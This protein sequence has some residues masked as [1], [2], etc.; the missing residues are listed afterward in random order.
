MEQSV[1]VPTHKQGHILDWIVY[2][3]DDNI[4]LSSTVTNKLTSDHL[5][6]LCNLDLTVPEPITEQRLR[7]NINSIDKQQFSLDIKLELD[8]VGNP[9]AEQFHC[10]LRSILDNHAP[11]SSA[12]VRQHKYSPWYRE[13]CAELQA[14]KRIRRKAE[15]RWLSS[16]LTV[17]KEIY[18]EA[19]MQVTKIVHNAKSEY[20]SS[21]IA[22]CT[23][24]K[25]LFNV[26]DKL[27][28]RNIALPLPTSVS[29]ECLPKLFSTFFHDKVAKI[30]EHLDSG[31]TTHELPSP[32]SHDVEYQHT[33]FT[34]FEP[35]TTEHLLSILTKCAP[36]SSDLDPMP[37]SLLLDC[38]DVVLPSMTDIINDSLVSGVFPSF[39]K[40][41]IVKPLLK[42]S[43]LDPNDMK[44]YRPVS[45]LSFMSKIL[46]KWLHI[47]FYLI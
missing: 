29:V 4:L 15:R 40:S 2:R 14:A 36:K 25:Q 18:I 33:P 21:K 28:G 35:V 19:K 7:R 31:T 16:K 30:R 38:L 23:N 12:I 32:Y 5:A 45:N 20:F 41:A 47:N 39:Y 10:C 24:C 13:I 46:E 3:P 44:N 42:K 11:L 34:S 9:S 17:H 22:K 43:T 37:T 6:I 1:H 27:L 26:A 8:F